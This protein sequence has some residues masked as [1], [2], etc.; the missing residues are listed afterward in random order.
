[1]LPAYF[2]L[3]LWAVLQLAGSLPGL[4]GVRTGWTGGSEP[5]LTQSVCQLGA[6]PARLFGNPVQPVLT[7]HTR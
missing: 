5:R 7:P 4:A 3:V 6:I 2:M 1:M